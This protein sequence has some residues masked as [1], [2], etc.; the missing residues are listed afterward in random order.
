MRLVTGAIRQGAGFSAHMVS[1]SPPS[2]EHLSLGHPPRPRSSVPPPPGSLPGLA[3]LHCSLAGPPRTSFSCPLSLSCLCG[4][5]QCL[6][7]WLKSRWQDR[8]CL[9]PPPSNLAFLPLWWA[10]QPPPYAPIDPWFKCLG[11]PLRP[12][13]LQVD[14]NPSLLPSLLLKWKRWLSSR[15]LTFHLCSGSHVPLPPQG[16]VPLPDSLYRCLLCI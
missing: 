7:S 1:C 10:P 14:L 3:S 15:R 12:P 5:A 4:C 9:H 8:H 16:A 13:V 2:P 6:F 11:D